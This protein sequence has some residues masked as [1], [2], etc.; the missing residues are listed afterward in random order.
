MT[1]ST[2]NKPEQCDSCE[3]ATDNIE[4]F[5]NRNY[6]G[7]P[8]EFVHTWLCDLCASTAA[9]HSVRLSRSI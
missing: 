4:R 7:R 1:D 6:Q 8:G 9:W 5:P 3:F 2:P